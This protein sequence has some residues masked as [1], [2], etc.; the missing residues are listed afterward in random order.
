[1][2]AARNKKEYS[3]GS[4]EKRKEPKEKRNIFILDKR[5]ISTI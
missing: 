5:Y 3:G 1:L 2:E 4:K